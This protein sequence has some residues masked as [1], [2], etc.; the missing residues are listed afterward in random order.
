[1][2]THVRSTY[3]ITCKTNTFQLNTFC[4]LSDTNIPKE[5]EYENFDNI[6][7]FGENCK[8]VVWFEKLFP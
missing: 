2:S 4:S 6:T 5:P 3:S 7:K 1:M 8:F